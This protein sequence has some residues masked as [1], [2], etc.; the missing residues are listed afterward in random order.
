[1]PYFRMSLCLKRRREKREKPLPVRNTNLCQ[2]A[3]SGWR[4]C[5]ATAWRYIRGA[6]EDG[7]KKGTKAWVLQ[8]TQRPTWDNSLP[9]PLTARATGWVSLQLCGLEANKLDSTLKARPGTQPLSLAIF[10]TVEQAWESS[11]AWFLHL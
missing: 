2:D 10:C 11:K 3:Q 4:G 5:L 1:M 7:R 8:D 6:K 9:P